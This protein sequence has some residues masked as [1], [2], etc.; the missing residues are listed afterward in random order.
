MNGQIYL[1]RHDPVDS[2]EER[3][4]MQNVM[5][6]VFVLEDGREI[7]VQ[8]DLDCIL[9]QGLHGAID[10]RP[11]SGNT[12]YIGASRFGSRPGDASL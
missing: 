7:R 11:E 4:T 9:V 5:W 3:T 10:I 6:V 8:N 1:V 2:E 12:V